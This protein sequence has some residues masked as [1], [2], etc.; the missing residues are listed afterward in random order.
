V[1]RELTSVIFT[2]PEVRIS[3]YFALEVVPNGELT[4]QCMTHLINH[5]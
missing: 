3:G 1:K 4:E 5:S 2:P